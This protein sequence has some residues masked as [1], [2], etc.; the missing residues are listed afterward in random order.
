MGSE[1]SLLKLARDNTGVSYLLLGLCR[2]LGLSAEVYMGSEDMDRQKLN[3][4]RMKM[5]VLR[6]ILSSQGPR[7]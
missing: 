4:Y 7:P 5:L 2:P 1:G 3:V 6:C